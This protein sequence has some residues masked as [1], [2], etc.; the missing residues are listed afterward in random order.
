[1]VCFLRKRK[2]FESSVPTPSEFQINY[3]K[4]ISAGFIK[5]CNLLE[6]FLSPQATQS[7]MHERK[8]SRTQKNKMM[9]RTF[10]YARLHGAIKMYKMHFNMFVSNI[11]SLQSRS[12]SEMKSSREVRREETSE[13]RK[14]KSLDDCGQRFRMLQRSAVAH[15]SVNLSVLVIEYLHTFQNL[16]STYRPLCS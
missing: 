8:Y 2:T 6:P 10:E 13:T 7:I 14:L 4:H 12:M 15:L 5:K 11:N 9:K 16:F 3:C 1:M